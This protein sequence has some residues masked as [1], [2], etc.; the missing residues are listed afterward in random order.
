MTKVKLTIDLEDVIEEDGARCDISCSTEII[1]AESGEESDVTSIIITKCINELMQR[2]DLIK[3]L[4]RSIMT[5]K[6][7]VDQS[8]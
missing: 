8:D 5:E 4:C 6:L 3:I 1:R 2:E 7:S